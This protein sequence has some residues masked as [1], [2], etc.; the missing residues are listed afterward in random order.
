MIIS[1]LVKHYNLAR[2]T[3]M[4]VYI[5][6]SI[7][8]SPPRS[9]H[10]INLARLEKVDPSKLQGAAGQKGV[11]TQRKQANAQHGGGYFLCTLI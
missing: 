4:Y 3:Y 5:Y 11:V 7:W 2:H 1:R 10:L 8:F 9:T 6:I